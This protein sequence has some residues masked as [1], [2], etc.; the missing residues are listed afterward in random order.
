MTFIEAIDR[1]RIADGT[2]TH[3]LQS[4]PQVTIS[5]RD[6][7][8]EVDSEID[9]RS[10]HLR[11]LRFGS[12]L[13]P[14]EQTEIA[15]LSYALDQLHVKREE[16]I[17]DQVRAHFGT[18]TST[19]KKDLIRFP[20]TSLTAAQADVLSEDS[21]VDVQRLLARSKHRGLLS[22]RYADELMKS[23][24][25]IVREAY[26]EQNDRV[27][28]SVLESLAENDAS[29]IVRSAASSQLRFRRGY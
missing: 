6:I 18:L 1:P 16:I 22:E 10:Q 2:F 5:S 27:P 25:S 20:S 3:K 9:L 23:S 19:E 11:E 24:D 4:D 21:D 13:G 17:R 28:S 8:A 15:D 7:A 12:A 26:I 14:A 29:T